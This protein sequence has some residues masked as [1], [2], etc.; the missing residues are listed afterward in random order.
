MKAMTLFAV[1]LTVA[2]GSAFSIDADTAALY[3]FKDGDDGVAVSGT[4][5]KNLVDAGRFPGSTVTFGTA[6][7]GLTFSAERPG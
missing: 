6:G 3:D 7:G 2:A 4:P 1:A 5:V